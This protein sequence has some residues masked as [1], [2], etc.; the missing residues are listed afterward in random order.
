VESI[1]TAGRVLAAACIEIERLKAYGSVVSRRCEAKE[2]ILA[3]R[4]V[5]IGVTTIRR[6]STAKLMLVR[7]SPKARIGTGVFMALN[8]AELTR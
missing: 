8:V 4:G 5:G 7:A 1:I 3:L 6:R 2:S